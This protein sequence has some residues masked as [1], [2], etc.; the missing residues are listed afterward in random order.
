MILFELLLFSSR[1]LKS[2]AFQSTLEN[3]KPRKSGGSFDL[4]S[5]E[6]GIICMNPWL[7]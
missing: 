6:R 2:L 3:N 7:G 1:A 5:G 4:L